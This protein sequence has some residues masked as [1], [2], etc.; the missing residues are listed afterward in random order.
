[1]AAM[2]TLRMIKDG[3][4]FPPPGL[5]PANEADVLRTERVVHA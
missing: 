5:E 2:F 1:V 4:A 3:A